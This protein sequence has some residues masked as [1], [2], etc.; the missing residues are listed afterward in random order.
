MKFKITL[1][2]RELRFASPKE[3]VIEITSSAN[4]ARDTRL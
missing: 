2:N 3:E 4:E 1:N